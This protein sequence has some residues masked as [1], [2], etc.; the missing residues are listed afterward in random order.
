MTFASADDSAIFG[1]PVRRWKLVARCRRNARPDVGRLKIVWCQFRPFRTKMSKVGPG[2]KWRL[3]PRSWLFRQL[4][5][6]IGGL[7][8]MIER[9]PIL[10]QCTR[11]SGLAENEFWTGRTAFE[12]SVSCAQSC[13][14]ASRWTSCDKAKV[15]DFFFGSKKKK[16]GSMSAPSIVDYMRSSSHS[17]GGKNI[18]KANRGECVSTPRD[19]TT[20]EPRNDHRKSYSCP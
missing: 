6:D 19:R 10:E 3:A 12:R 14:S 20:H 1:R 11:P 18:F 7:W 13:V 16:N 8:K 9:F 15:G 5:L 2:P 4:C 17:D